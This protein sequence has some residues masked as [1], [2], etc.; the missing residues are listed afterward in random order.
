VRLLAEGRASEIFALD[1]ERVL[2]R[3]KA[4]GDPANE[5]HVM[6]RA[7][8]HGY[9]VP[10]VF[11]VRDDALVLERVYGPSMKEEG[12]RRP[13]L[14]EELAQALALLHDRLHEIPGED[15]GV[16]LHLDLHPENV[17]MSPD[18]PV[19]VDWANARDGRGELDPALTWLILMT[20]GGGRDRNVSADERVAVRKLVTTIS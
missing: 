19:V 11:D 4:G 14:M 1:D 20:S 6:E 17:L 18:G 7:L 9:P 8:A 12:F 10:Q 13:Q 2:R 16:I 3:F 5:A 15:S